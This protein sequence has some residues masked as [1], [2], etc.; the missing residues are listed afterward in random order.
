MTEPITRAILND[1]SLTRPKDIHHVEV[2]R[3]HIEPGYAGGLHVHNG[4]V[5]GNIVEG[6]AV[7]QIEG[8]AESVL[9][10]GDVFYEPEQTRI[11]R[12]DAGADGVTFLAYFLLEEG[13]ASELIPLDS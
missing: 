6:S 5:F 8:Q 2:R 10:A 11:A 7:Y 12:F 3:I 13:Q 1:F 9:E 4:P